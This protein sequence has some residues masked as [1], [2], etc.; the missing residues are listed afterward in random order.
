MHLKSINRILFQLAQ[1]KVEL[2]IA[3]LLFVHS[4]KILGTCLNWKTIL[5][6]SPK[7][8]KVNVNFLF[9]LRFHLGKVEKKQ[10][11]IKL[12]KLPSLFPNSMYKAAHW[13][14]LWSLP[15]FRFKLNLIAKGAGKGSGVFVWDRKDDLKEA[16]KQLSDEE[17][18]EEVIYDPSTRGRPCFNWKMLQEQ[19]EIVKVTM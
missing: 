15:H 10:H 17:V 4:R 6:K 11:K 2:S 12:K 14:I 5:V 3:I 18:Y 7:K 13:T 8:T 19:G 9:K 1:G 16:H